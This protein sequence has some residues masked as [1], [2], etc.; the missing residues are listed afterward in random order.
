MSALPGTFPIPV[1]SALLGKFTTDHKCMRTIF[2]L[3]DEHLVYISLSSSHDEV[4]WDSVIGADKGVDVREFRSTELST[5]QIQ[6]V[7]IVPHAYVRRPE[8]KVSDGEVLAA[9]L[10]T[11]DSITR[12]LQY[13]LTTEE[14]LNLCSYAGDL[15]ANR[16]LERW[17]IGCASRCFS[18]GQWDLTPAE[19]LENLVKHVNQP[20]C[21]PYYRFDVPF[22]W[23]AELMDNPPLV[24]V[25]HDLVDRAEPLG[26]SSVCDTDNVRHILQQVLILAFNT[27]DAIIICMR[28]ERFCD[29]YYSVDEWD[30]EGGLKYRALTAAVEPFQAMIGDPNSEVPLHVRRILAFGNGLSAVCYAVNLIGLHKHMLPGAVS[31][32]DEQW[33]SSLHESVF[34]SISKTV[35]VLA[36]HPR[37]RHTAVLGRLISEIE[38]DEQFA[39]RGGLSEDYVAW[40]CYEFN[41]NGPRPYDPNS[42][43]DDSDDEM[44][45]ATLDDVPLQAVGPR[46]SANSVSDVVTVT[47]PTIPP[48]DEAQSAENTAESTAENPCYICLDAFASTTDACMQL[49]NCEHRLHA[50]CLEAWINGVFTSDKGLATVGCPC[51]RTFVCHAR[52]YEGRPN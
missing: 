13:Q 44:L 45:D 48:A 29:P 25:F 23:V 35:E 28:D 16:S 19:L 50:L 7:D 15:L 14:T 31:P 12:A 11:R 24:Q 43:E 41:Q 26:G 40:Y 10:S 3:L 33:L 52:P 2:R 32:E 36:N 6:E 49:R 38:Q 27:C 22:G 39:N 18:V 42:E 47:A 8:N 34:S 1:L 30:A 4:D 37:F 51:C 21:H 17:W 5:V 20:Q 46:I 9:W